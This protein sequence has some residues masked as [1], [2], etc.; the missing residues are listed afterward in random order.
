[1]D[2]AAQCTPAIPSH[3]GARYYD[4]WIMFAFAIIALVAI[5]SRLTG[6]E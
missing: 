1:M 6:Q 4:G 3:F 2:F 5:T